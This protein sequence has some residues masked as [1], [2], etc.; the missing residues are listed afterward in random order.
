MKLKVDF[1]SEDLEKMVV[2]FFDGSGF[3]VIDLSE[4]MS[5][6]ETAF[7]EGLTVNVTPK[8]Q[9]PVAIPEK[10][11]VKQEGAPGEMPTYGPPDPEEAPEEPDPD[12]PANNGGILTMTE[13][14]DPTPS[15]DDLPKMYNLLRE[16]DALK[17]KGD[18]NV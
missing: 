1:D 2:E 15:D 6:F 5:Q 10:P 3:D 13:I 17:E 8:A 16:S 12:S 7:P 11:L 18:D 4:V 14:M 9:A